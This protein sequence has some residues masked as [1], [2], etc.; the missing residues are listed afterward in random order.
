MK[1]E[2]IGYKQDDYGL[3][4]F[5]LCGGDSIEEVEAKLINDGFKKGKDGK[6]RG[7]HFVEGY[8]EADG[9]LEPFCD[10]HYVEVSIE[11]TEDL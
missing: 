11:N 5:Q 2:A 8:Y 6:I 7:W 4:S 10:A 9:Y 3:Y 1:Y